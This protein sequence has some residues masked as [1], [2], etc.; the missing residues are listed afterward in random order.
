MK[1]RKCQIVTLIIFSA[2]WIALM[3]TLGLTQYLQLH[4]DDKLLH[5]VCFMVLTML[6]FGIVNA[7][8]GQRWRRRHSPRVISLTDRSADGLLP[9]P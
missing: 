9:V 7:A 6:A 8:T 1:R 3:A 5:F 4:V 2:G